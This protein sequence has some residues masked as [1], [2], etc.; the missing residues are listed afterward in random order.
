MIKGPP[1][2][3]ISLQLAAKAAGP[4]EIRWIHLWPERRAKS[5]KDAASRREG[6]PDGGGGGG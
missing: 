4:G 2:I 3:A 5:M 6:A 1:L